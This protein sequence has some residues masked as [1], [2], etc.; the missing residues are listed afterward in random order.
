MNKT[1]WKGEYY[2][3][4]AHV[5]RGSTYFSIRRNE[6]DCICSYVTFPWRSLEATAMKALRR[7]KKL[8]KE[9]SEAN[10]KVEEISEIQ[11]VLAEI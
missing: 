11:R 5:C 10:E 8:D 1:I 3:V 4:S 9:M 7:A 2:Y 6:Y